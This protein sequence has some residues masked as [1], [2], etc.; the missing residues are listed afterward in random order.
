MLNPPLETSL[1]QQ[2]LNRI[3]EGDDQAR[4]LLISHSM[5]RLR[6]LASNMLRDRQSVRRWDDTDDVLQNS[7][8][9]LNRALQVVTPESPRRYIGLAATQIR[10]ELLDLYRHH[11]G[12]EGHAAHHASD[13][14]KADT[15]GNILQ[16]YDSPDQQMSPATQASI[17]EAIDRLPDELREVFDMTFYQGMTQ[18]EIAGV[19][20][21]ST[22]T[23]KRRWRDARLALQELLV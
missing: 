17:H 22:K 3:A 18:E 14:G 2:L 16:S 1:T 9:R 7:L 15:Q 10:R 21:L 11:Y 20:D 8:I 19:L 6:R 5:D 23:I 12:P 13:L 4:T